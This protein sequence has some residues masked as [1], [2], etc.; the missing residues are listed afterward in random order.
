MKKIL[1]LLLVIVLSCGKEKRLS[2]EIIVAEPETQIVAEQFSYIRGSIKSGQ[3]LAQALISKGLDNASAYRLANELNKKYD[4]RKSNPADSFIVKIDSSKVVQELVYI[5]NK[6]NTYR[7]VLDSTRNYYV[8]I[9]TLKT[10]KVIKICD[11]TI[12]SSLWGAIVDRQREGPALAMMLSQIFQWDIDFNVDPQKGDSFKIVYEQYNNELGAFV[13]YG[14]ILAANYT[15]KSYSKTAYRYQLKN[16]GTHYYD[17]KGA[18]FQKAFL[19]SPLNYTRISSGFGNRTHPITKQ[20]RFHNGVDYAAPYGTPVEAVADGTVIH[21]DWK[22]GHP[23]INGRSGG[24][25]KTVIIRHAN[26]FETLYGHLSNYGKFKVGAR[27]KQH[28]IIGYVGSTGLSTGNHLHYTM[29][30]NGKPIDPLKIKNVNGPP[31][32]SSEMASFK[33]NVDLYNQYLN[34]E[35]KPKNYSPIADY[36]RNN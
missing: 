4:L 15:S 19:R 13:R 34:E 14:N 31:I 5:P 3:P 2:E 36:Y 23:T 32:P 16:A 35:K 21:C 33:Q 29:F 27:V 6:I 18:S 20:V 7:V 1:W 28:D 17:E 30:Q 8:L 22:G 12:E 9:D 24:Y 11:G 10:S 25:G 26:N